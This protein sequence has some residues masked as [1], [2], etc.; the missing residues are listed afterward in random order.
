MSS[1]RPRTRTAARSITS[2]G[3]IAQRSAASRYSAVLTPFARAAASAAVQ[4]HSSS[5]TRTRTFVIGQRLL[6]RQMPA[7]TDVQTWYWPAGGIAGALCVQKKQWNLSEDP[8]RCDSNCYELLVELDTNANLNT[9]GIAVE[10][11][12]N[13]DMVSN[14]HQ[15]ADG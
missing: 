12:V 9:S 2:N 4:T 7:K 15:A 5:D 6:A 3:S 13:A 11:Y 8:P 1:I 14:T 10:C